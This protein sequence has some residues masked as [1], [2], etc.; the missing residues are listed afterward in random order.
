MITITIPAW[1][2]YTFLGLTL[3]YTFALIGVFLLF[4]LSPD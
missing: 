4:M 2:V 1:L 3:F